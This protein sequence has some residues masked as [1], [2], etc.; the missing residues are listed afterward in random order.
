MPDTGPRPPTIRDAR[1][2]VLRGL[3]LVMIFINHIPGTMWEHWTSRNFGFSDAA[4]AFVLM[5]GISAGLAYGNAFRLSPHGQFWSG[6]ARVWRRA[7]TLYLV[8]LT[9]TLWALGI[10]AFFAVAFNLPD[11]LHRNAVNWLYQ[12]PLGFLI[13]LPLLTHQLGYANILP[14]Y[15]VLLFASPP[16]II[17]AWRHPRLLLALSVVLWFL[18]AQFR[19]NLPSH[20]MPGGWFFNPLS[21]Q[22]LFVIGLLTGTALKDGRRFVPVRLWLQLLAGA[23]LLLALLVARIDAVGSTFG[24]SLWLLQEL[25]AP[26]WITV[27]DKTF[28]HLPRLLHIL[29]LAYLLSTLPV[30]ARACAHRAAAPLALLGQQALPVFA[31]GTVLCYIGQGIKTHTGVDPVIDTALIATG[32]ALQYALARARSRWPRDT[33]AGAA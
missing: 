5:S 10:A 6:L 30:V 12:D 9:V 7:W 13:G 28:L 8:H 1:L 23:Y 21:W 29:A 18:A 17:L 15:A 4:E 32:L 3:A 19:V 2:D 33:G 31:L 20:P 11:L 26:R 27:F 24:H 14:L 16:A 22:L 25:G